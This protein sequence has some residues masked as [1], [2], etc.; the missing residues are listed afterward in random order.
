[1]MTKVLLNA[2]KNEDDA[3][4]FL[5]VFHKPFLGR[6]RFKKA[7]IPQKIVKAK[8]GWYKAFV[9]CKPKPNPMIVV[10]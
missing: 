6:V 1:M 10:K 7:N 4:I 9:S 8:T 5:L 2:P 3:R